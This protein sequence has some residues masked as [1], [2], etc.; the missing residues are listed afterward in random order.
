MNY[1][2]V[3]ITGGCGFIGSNFIE[4]LMGKKPNIRVIN[5]DKLSYASSI[6]VNNKFKKLKNYS[7]FKCNIKNDKIGEIIKKLYEQE[8]KQGHNLTIRSSKK[9]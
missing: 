1:K 3:L 6:R 8:I 5:V 9:H 4:Y 2:S 7:F